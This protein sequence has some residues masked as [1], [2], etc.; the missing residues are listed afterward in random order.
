MSGTILKEISLGKTVGI[1]DLT[2]GIRDSRIKIE[3]RGSKC[4]KN[5]GFLLENLEMRRFF[6]DEKHQLEIKKN[7]CTDRILC[8]VIDDRHIDH[9]SVS[10]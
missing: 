5:F 6:N 4:C 1:I 3:I 7:N 8:Y 10:F 9:G 2:E